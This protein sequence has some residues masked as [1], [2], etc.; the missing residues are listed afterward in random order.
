MLHSIGSEEQKLIIL[1]LRA[2]W[3]LSSRNPGLKVVKNRPR[4]VQAQPD[5]PY[6]W[7]RPAI[8]D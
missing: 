5:P 3:Y 2:L 8:K 7:E 1:A 6:S 4:R